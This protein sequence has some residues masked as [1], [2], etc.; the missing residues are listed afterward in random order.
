MA[1]FLHVVAGAIL[2]PIAIVDSVSVFIATSSLQTK[3]SLTKQHISMVPK[4]DASTNR[5]EPTTAEEKAEAGYPP[6]GSLIRQGPVPF[7]RRLTDPDGY[8]Q[9]VLKYMGTELCDRNEAQGNMDAYMQNPNDWTLQKIEEKNGAPKYDYA[10]ANMDTTQLVLT[11]AWAS[12][13]LAVLTRVA[14]VSVNGC[15]NF[16]QKY[17][18]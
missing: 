4:Y 18:W 14:Y 12:V 17:H 6:I 10:N 1:F 11:G 2:W 13:L 8:D 9:G 3:T 5:W 15:D 16:C 7:F